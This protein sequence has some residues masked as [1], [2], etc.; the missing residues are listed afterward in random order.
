MMATVE[1]DA[2]K[3]V[4]WGRKEERGEASGTRPPEPCEA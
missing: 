2:G 1:A 3:G 4:T